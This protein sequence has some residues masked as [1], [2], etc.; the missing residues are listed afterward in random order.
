[1]HITLK[2]TQRLS[3]GGNWLQLEA[4]IETQLMVCVVIAQVDENEEKPHPQ[5][6]EAQTDLITGVAVGLCLRS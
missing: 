1:M 6:P 4:I 2:V 5:T 3:G